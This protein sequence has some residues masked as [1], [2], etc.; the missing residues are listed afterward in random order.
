[1]IEEENRPPAASSTVPVNKVHKYQHLSGI[2]IGTDEAM[3]A[4][5]DHAEHAT[6]RF[7]V[8]QLKIAKTTPRDL[9]RQ[10][11]TT[12]LEWWRKKNGAVAPLDTHR[13]SC[14]AP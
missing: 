3:H 13:F 8:H 11:I 12:K 1:V 6:G 7:A 14:Q 10:I 2:D 4:F 5:Q 9:L